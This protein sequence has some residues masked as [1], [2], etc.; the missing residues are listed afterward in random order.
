M[1]IRRGG[2]GPVREVGERGKARIGKEKRKER[3]TGRRKEIR[4]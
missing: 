3:E 1:G 4:E 2:R